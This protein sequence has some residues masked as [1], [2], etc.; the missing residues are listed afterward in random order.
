MIARNAAAAGRPDRSRGRCYREAVRGNPATSIDATGPAGS[1]VERDLPAIAFSALF[2]ALLL[3]A[4]A[5]LLDVSFIFGASLA[6]GILVP[7]AGIL[8]GLAAY[9]RGRPGAR[10]ILFVTSVAALIVVAV[11][12]V[13]PDFGEY[14]HLGGAV[15]PAAAAAV[16]GLAVFVGVGMSGSSA[17][18]ST[19]VRTVRH[20]A[21]AGILVGLVALSI[22]VQ[23]VADLGDTANGPPTNLGQY[24]A[25]AV[26]IRVGVLAI[27]LVAWWW[28]TG[29]LLAVTGLSTVVGVVAYSLAYVPAASAVPTALLGIASIVAGLWPPLSQMS[30]SADQPSLA[31]EPPLTE[32]RLAPEPSP[33]RPTV[34]AVWPVLG[35]LLFIPTLLFARVIERM[36]DC[37]DNCPVPSPL[38]GLAEALDLPLVILF[39]ILAVRLA[40]L[41]SAATRAVSTVGLA[42][43][44]FV[45]AQ[46]ALGQLDTTP[47]EF[48]GFVAPAALLMGL[49]F[50]A[51]LLPRRSLET[52]ALVA[53]AI[54]CLVIVWVWS[55]F[56]F[57]FGIAWPLHFSALI[58]AG[59][60]AL[61]LAAAFGHA[62]RNT[63]RAGATELPEGQPPST[64]AT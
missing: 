25:S 53:M 35:A 54:G 9:R 21:V 18:A 17:P 41:S 59:V 30:P 55:S 31:T 6:D 33:I 45:F 27:A 40:F 60:A 24:L 15:L 39:V 11:D 36:G 37:F 10:P 63:T 8:I 58:E 16:S 13:W 34:A 57:T 42:A 26:A 5:S 56:A 48:M 4:T 50:G 19:L 44:L 2:A 51:A 61:A 32:P 12:L 38:A 46:I 22:G 7:C 47:F 64:H 52:G 23:L 1:R 29:W 3:A 49:G 20:R 14:P 43:A 28:G 62:E